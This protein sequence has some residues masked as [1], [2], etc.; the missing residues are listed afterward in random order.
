MK[1]LTVCSLALLLTSAAS[2]AVIKVPQDHATISLA[3]AA[4]SAGDTILVK[5]GVYEENVTIGAGLIGLKIQGLGQVIVDARPSGST[6]TG[7]GIEIQADNVTLQNLMIRHAKG[8]NPHGVRSSSPGTVLNGVRVQHAD[9][10]GIAV[11]GDDAFLNK[12]EVVDSGGGITIAGN[13]AEVVKA[14][15][16]RDS[17]DGITI[18]GDDAKV[19]KCTVRAV[20][21]PGITVVGANATIQTNE[22]R[23]VVDAVVLSGTG[24]LITKNIVDACSGTGISIGNAAA[25]S[26][27][28]NSVTDM[29][30]A[31]LLVE[32]N[33][34]GLTIDKNDL[35]RTG[36]NY[37]AAVI[38]EGDGNTM[39]NTLVRQCAGDGILVSGDNNTFFKVTSSEHGEDGIQFTGAGNS[40]D[41]CVFRKNQGEGAQCDGANN[42]LTKS[43]AKLNRID[44]AASVPFATFNLNAFTTGGNATAPEI[45]D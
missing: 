25:G 36:S 34:T 23:R 28:K 18:T 29:R 35:R 40:A 20:E 8:V 44:V 4:A 41:K 9:G 22:V 2:A 27:A 45:D 7:P 21:G 16:H 1:P 6:G 42:A 31:C 10:A 39:T 3:V 19:T 11:F 26:I 30:Q 43:I 37:A 32:S 12:C 33:A 15:V 14:L 38:M 24:G 17:A 5:S 13:G